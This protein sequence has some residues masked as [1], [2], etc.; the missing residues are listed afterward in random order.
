MYPFEGVHQLGQPS[1]SWACRAKCWGWTEQPT[2]SLCL[3]TTSF[4]SQFLF[5]S[6]HQAKMQE[7]Y[8][9][10]E[11]K[12]QY[13]RSRR[14]QACIFLKMEEEGRA[15]PEVSQTGIGRGTVFGPPR[16][17][18]T[19]LRRWTGDV[20][21]SGEE[22]SLPVPLLDWV[23]GERFKQNWN[24][25]ISNNSSTELFFFSCKR[26]FILHCTRLFFFLFF[27]SV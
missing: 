2:A 4:H 21:T 25:F 7:F 24:V 13:R 18:N 19:C 27:A 22:Q 11:E 20:T 23:K 9:K 8:L 1:K 3:N 17:W 14:K 10:L 12:K 5:L 15:C 16:K 26:N 6:S